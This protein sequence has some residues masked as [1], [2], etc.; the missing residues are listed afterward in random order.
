M[1]K[2]DA[3][4]EIVEESRRFVEQNKGYKIIDTKRHYPSPRL[5]S[6]FTDCSMPMTFDHYSHCSLG[7]L[8]CFAYFFKSNNPS[9]RSD[10][11]TV[12]IKGLKDA[13]AGRPSDSRSKMMH[14]NF[15]KKKFLLHWGGLADPFC[16]FE[17]S[18]RHGLSLLHALGRH[19]Y[20][21]LFSF[22]GASI[23]E[24]DYRKVLCLVFF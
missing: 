9:F 7:C 12:N 19:N 1:K 18:N 17:H 11:G 8:Y 3:R 4:S 6:E 13:L 21:T 5:S 22:K 20:P 14:R 24:K 23:F 2:N 16:H 10:L 15:I